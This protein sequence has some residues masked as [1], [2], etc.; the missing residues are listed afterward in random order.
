MKAAD[1]SGRNSGQTVCR[2]TVVTSASLSLVMEIIRPKQLLWI[3]LLLFPSVCTD[4]GS[5]DMKQDVQ[6]I[7]WSLEHLTDWKMEPKCYRKFMSSTEPLKCEKDLRLIVYKTPDSVSISAVGHVGP[8]LEGEQ[9]QLQCEV[10]NI[11]PVQYL[12]VKW[13]KGETLEDQTTYDDLTK[14]PVNVSSTLLITP[15]STDDRAQYSCVAELELGPEGPE[16]HPADT[17]EPL[18]I[19]VHY[20]GR[21]PLVIWPDT[22]VVRFGDPLSVNCTVSE[23]HMGIGWEASEGSVDMK[24]DVQFITWSLE[25]L[26]DWKM[27]PKCYGNF[28]INVKPLQCE[29]ELKVIVYKTP[30]SVSI[31]AVGHVGPM[32]EGEQ[33]QLQCEVQNITPVQNLTVKWYKGETLED[34]TTYD[35]LTKTP[36]NVSSTLLITPTSTD[37]GAQ[38]SCV[39]ELE[40]GPEGPEPHPADKSEPLTITVHYP[41]EFEQVNENVTVAQGEEVI[42]SCTAKGNPIPTINWHTSSA[43][44]HLATRERQNTLTISKASSHNAGIYTCIARNYLGTASRRIMVSVPNEDYVTIVMVVLGIILLLLLLGL[45]FYCIKRKRSRG[46]YYFSPAQS[47][48]RTDN[49]IPLMPAN[50]NG[51]A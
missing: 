49:S 50:S 47:D 41:P 10:Q 23:D 20:P 7:T 29:K 6:F 40:L 15:T 12:T 14:T 34:Q 22:V 36:V 35:D 4:E 18:T 51:I 30:D 33:Y 32:L 8:M 37:D 16:P 3:L 38:Y 45:I 31:S 27:E 11:A 17:S 48:R 24:Q 46:Q 2:A 13:Y 42:L 5:V 21:C 28:L 44:T 9:Y 25:H 1:S 26:M 39:A 43:E 19:T